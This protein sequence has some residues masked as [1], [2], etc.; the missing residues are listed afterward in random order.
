MFI[1]I[2]VAT[3][4]ALSDASIIVHAEFC[5]WLCR[6]VPDVECTVATLLKLCHSHSCAYSIVG[7]GVCNVGRTNMAELERETID[8]QTSEVIASGA[9]RS[10][11]V[12]A[13]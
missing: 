9:E 4:V 1:P 13:L 8:T 7:S 11:A 12:R 6:L 10:M 5:V 2:G 3:T